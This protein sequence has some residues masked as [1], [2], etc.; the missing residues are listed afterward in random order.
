MSGLVEDD[1]VSLPSGSENEAEEETE[2]EVVTDLSDTKVVTK[3]LEASR[4]ANLALT[5]LVPHIVAGASV[6][7][8]IVIG[9]SIIDKSLAK[10]YNKKEDGKDVQ[11]GIAFP[12]CL[13][14]NERICNFSPLKSEADSAPALLA[15]DVVKIDLGCHIDGYI[16]CTAHTVIVPTSK[17]ATP[18][19]PSP[20][21]GD[22]AKACHDAMQVAAALIKPGNTNTMVTTALGKVAEAYGVKFIANVRMHQMKHFVIDGSK[23]IALCAPDVEAGEERVAECTFEENEVY[24]IDVA[25]STGTGKGREGEDRT[26][27]FKRNVDQTYKLKM[28]ASKYV[29]NQIT[30]DFPTMPFSLRMVEDERQAKMGVTELVTHNLLSAYPVFNERDGAFVAHFKTTVLVMTSGSKKVTGEEL[31][32]YYVTEKILDEE[33]QA[34]L[35]EVKAAE[36]KKKAKAAAK[37]KKKKAKK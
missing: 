10:I 14:V 21:M 23:E 17:D 7:D 32:G 3:Y 1:D 12:V 36:E 22:V 11:K 28:K 19:L 29:L 6:L 33:N 20:E 5:T 24:C 30:A 34:L 8:L 15:G 25:M 18:V 26:T 2:K 9:E 27:V 13:S 35:D 31:P 4:I 16:A 37:K